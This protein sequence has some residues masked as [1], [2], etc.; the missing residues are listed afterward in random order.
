MKLQPRNESWP[1]CWDDR[2]RGHALVAVLSLVWLVVQWH[3]WAATSP[4]E[5]LTVAKQF[6]L[7]QTW[8][9]LEMPALYEREGPFL[10]YG[11]YSFAIG[12]GNTLLTPDE[13]D[14]GI[15]ILTPSSR[16]LCA[17][18]V[19]MTNMAE[20]LSDI[21]CDGNLVYAGC[22]S[23]PRV[24]VF[25]VP[26]GR[27]V[28]DIA[29]RSDEPDDSIRPVWAAPTVS[30]VG[31]DSGGRLHALYRE[32]ADNGQV[33]I[34]QATFDHDGKRVRPDARMSLQACQGVCGP[35]GEWLYPHPVRV[36]VGAGPALAT[37]Y[38]VWQAVPDGPPVAMDRL[39]GL[40]GTQG[41]VRELVGVDGKEHLYGV[42][43]P[44]RWP[45][46]G[47]AESG[48][49]LVRWERSQRHVLGRITFTPGNKRAYGSRHAV[50]TRDGAVYALA[51]D[52]LPARPED[53]LSLTLVRFEKLP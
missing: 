47:E 39:D 33:V 41:T 42:V 11:P 37:R 12:P 1:G 8:R 25:E 20:R 40:A 52:R 38:E 23:S 15:V 2:S 29:L 32:A 48:V 31:L 50:V 34:M 6:V 16:Q 13:E 53:Q 45:P 4:V 24:L 51:A 28:R 9:A 46:I 49:F 18:R 30:R 3:C 35:N 43:A 7:R 17:P 19:H 44:F 26:S 10:Q 22:A 5:T 27:V 14:T 21:I 36:P